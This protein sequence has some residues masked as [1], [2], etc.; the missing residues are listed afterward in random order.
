[1]CH[2]QASSHFWPYYVKCSGYSSLIVLVYVFVCVDPTK[3]G[4]LSM[5]L[6]AGEHALTAREVPPQHYNLFDCITG[7]DYRLSR[8]GI[9]ALKKAVIAFAF[10]LQNF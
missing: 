7:K 6:L 4:G 2:G 10:V 3:M 9:V 1:M 8:A 5:L